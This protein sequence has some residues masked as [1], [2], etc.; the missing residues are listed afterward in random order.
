MSRL[1]SHGADH[2]Q[3]SLST[4]MSSLPTT[5]LSSSQS[6]NAVGLRDAFASC[7]KYRNLT[8]IREA[9]FETVDRRSQYLVA[10]SSIV[11]TTD[12]GES[13]FL[14]N[15]HSD[16]EPGVEDHGNRSSMY[17]M[18]DELMWDDLDS[19]FA[20]NPQNLSLPT[21]SQNVMSTRTIVPPSLNGVSGTRE[22]TPLLRKAVSFYD[23]TR[24]SPLYKFRNTHHRIGISLPSDTMS[25]QQSGQPC[26]MLSSGPPKNIYGGK[27]TFGQTVQYN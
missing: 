26:V 6:S 20:I 8:F 12:T 22:R 10:G 4:S 5:L 25:R 7:E 11:S 13:D 21:S 17:P 2:P 3:G 23:S 15:H 18:P 19:D 24:P 27:S 14:H 9:Y 1:I 16:N